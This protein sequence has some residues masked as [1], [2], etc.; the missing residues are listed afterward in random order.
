MAP[1]PSRR[2]A[3]IEH[4]RAHPPHAGGTIIDRVLID[5]ERLED[6]DPFVAFIEHAMVAPGGFPSHPHAGF[7][8]VT[9]VLEGALDYAEAGGASGRLEVGDLQWLR[10]GRGLVHSEEPRPGETCTI[11]QLWLNLPAA[12]KRDPPARQDLRDA[13]LPRV[14]LEP[15]LATVVAG[16]LAGV[17]GPADTATPVDLWD[18]RAEADGQ[19]RLPLAA[20]R[21]GFLIVLEG[22]LRAGPPGEHAVAR[23]GSVLRLADEEVADLELRVPAGSRFLL[24][25]GDPIGEPVASLGPF[26]FNTRAE[27]AD[28]LARLRRGEFPG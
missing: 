15:L 27:L 11:L 3:E 14:E 7:E 18:L 2:I 24:V 13:E 22:E 5:P 26:V 19:L 4:P 16:E 17:R 1:A 9:L 20:S 10:T 8:S 6:N 25:A 28:A 21:R 23:A 12:H